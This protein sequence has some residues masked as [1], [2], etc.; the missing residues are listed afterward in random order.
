M[1]TGARSTGW[2]V[3][4]QLLMLQHNNPITGKTARNASEIPRE[5]TDN[6]LNEAVVARTTWKKKY[7]LIPLLHSEDLP[8]VGAFVQTYSAYPANS[9]TICQPDR[10]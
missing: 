2:A 5:A 3:Q 4:Y 7:V 8:D 9:M 6:F 10:D 1:V